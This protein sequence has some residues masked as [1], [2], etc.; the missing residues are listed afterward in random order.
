MARGRWSATLMAALLLAAGVVFF[1]QRPAAAATDW[2]P[3]ITVN[4]QAVCMGWD[5][6]TDVA[7][8]VVESVSPEGYTYGGPA[9]FEASPTSTLYP[10]TNVL[11]APIQVKQVIPHG[12][13]ATKATLTVTVDLGVPGGK[14]IIRV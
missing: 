13:G 8:K 1:S 3:E 6:E 14:Q 11:S 9:T 12:S 4:G 10:N 2:M 7:W 5:G